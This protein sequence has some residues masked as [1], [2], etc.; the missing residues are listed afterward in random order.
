MIFDLL[1]VYLYSVVLLLLLKYKIL[2]YFVNLCRFLSVPNAYL[3]LLHFFFSPLSDKL[4][5]LRQMRE[6]S[7]CKRGQNAMPLICG[8]LG[9]KL[10][11]H[12]T[13]GQRA[14]HR[15]RGKEPVVMFV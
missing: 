13:R 7:K 14:R 1:T 10:V 5:D 3:M 6:V 8:L 9:H 11:S 12:V 15:V 2:E 4:A